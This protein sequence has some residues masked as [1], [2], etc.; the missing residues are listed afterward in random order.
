M[1]LLIYLVFSSTRLLV[2]QYNAIQ[3]CSA[4]ASPL[5]SATLKYGCSP[6][7]PPKCT[8]AH[9]NSTCKRRHHSTITTNKAARITTLNIEP[10]ASNKGNRKLTLDHCM[11]RKARWCFSYNDFATL[12]RFPDNLLNFTTF[13]TSHDRAVSSHTHID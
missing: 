8:K 11:E 13:P 9:S 12:L 3:Q 6:H 2:Y 4:R 5:L 10:L 1:R 7:V